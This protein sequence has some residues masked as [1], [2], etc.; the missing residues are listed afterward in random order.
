VAKII[1]EIREIRGS[2]FLFAGSSKLAADSL[3][4]PMKR[5]LDI[6]LSLILVILLGPILLVVALLVRIKLGTPV[7]FR[8]PRPGLHGKL[9]TMVKFRTMLSRSHDEQG[10]PLPDDQRL[11][12]FGQRLRSTSLDELPELFNV[13]KGDMSLVGPRPLMV[14]YL[15]RY[16]PEQ[17]RRHD[18]KPG[19]TGWAQVNGRNNMTWEQKFAYDVWYVDHQSFRLDLK[20]LALTVWHVI[21]RQDIAKDGHVTVDEFMGSPKE[22]TDVTDETERPERPKYNSPG[23]RPG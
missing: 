18:V 4:K 15:D 16:T 14:K 7:L 10:R 19:I 1:R 22:T 20:I 3:L 5:L 13:L 21:R 2:S 9:F 23:Q 11:T 17:H 8:Q 12:P 6:L